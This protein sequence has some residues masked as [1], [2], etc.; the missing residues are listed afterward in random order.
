VAFPGDETPA[1]TLAS[2]DWALDHIL[3]HG[4]SGYLPMRHAREALASGRLHLIGDAPRFRRRV[5]L[6]ASLQATAQWGWFEGAIAALRQAPGEIAD[7]RSGR[8][9][10]A[11]PGA[12]A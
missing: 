2:A 10:R 12:G 6:V 3:R 11:R 5:Y 7:Q 8:G 9:K 1:V 4:G